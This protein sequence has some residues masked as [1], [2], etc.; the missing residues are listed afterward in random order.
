MYRY[1]CSASG[2]TNAVVR[3]GVCIRHGANEKIKLCSAEDNVI[4]EPCTGMKVKEFAVGAGEK[5][6]S[7]KQQWMYNYGCTKVKALFE[8]YS[9]SQTY[10]SEEGEF[11]LALS[12]ELCLCSFSC[13]G[14]MVAG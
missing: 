3:G 8:N 4:I 5:K 13:V 1:E 2:C 6:P 12:I 7:I 10:L 11:S 14:M 9:Q